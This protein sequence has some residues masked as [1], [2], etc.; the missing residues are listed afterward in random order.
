M[1]NNGD[2][3]QPT[4][5]RPGD[6]PVLRGSAAEVL[7]G[8]PTDVAM[9]ATQAADTS[10][11][12]TE[13][14]RQKKDEVSLATLDIAALPDGFKAGVTS[15]ADGL[16]ITQDVRAVEALVT[17]H[18]RAVVLYKDL[19]EKQEA[20]LTGLERALPAAQA[21]SVN[22]GKMATLANTAPELA[23]REERTN[24]RAANG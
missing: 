10:S 3:Q 7:A 2:Q 12:E 11:S 23:R 20:R 9:S 17:K 4:A 6:Q 22:S 15:A 1:D 19:L 13:S 5:T 24:E 14:K 16:A 18:H 21:N 8:P